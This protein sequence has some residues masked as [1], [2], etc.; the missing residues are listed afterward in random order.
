MNMLGMGTQ[1]M[2]M[3]MK[4]KNVSSLEE[5]IQSAM[6]AGIEI[7]ACQMSLDVMGLRQEELLDG[8]KVGGVGY[9]LSEAED[10]NVNLF[11]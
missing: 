9:Y 7:V 8:V 6:N 10:S 5:L 3:V 2:R 11:I 4:N 1:M